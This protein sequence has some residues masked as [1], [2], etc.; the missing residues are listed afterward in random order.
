MSE[1]SPLHKLIQDGISRGMLGSFSRQ[2]DIFGEQLARE[3][4]QDPQFRSQVQA[5]MR[6]IGQSVLQQLGTGNGHD[7]GEAL[8]RIEARLTAIEQQLGKAQ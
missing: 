4:W 3:A 2:A 5:I 1:Q 7:V 8:A 6:Q